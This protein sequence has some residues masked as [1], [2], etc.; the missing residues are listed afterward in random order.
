MI[1]EKNYIHV[2]NN[3]QVG[4]EI[5]TQIPIINMTRHRLHYY[6]N[7]YDQQPRPEIKSSCS[8]HSGYERLE[9]IEETEHGHGPSQ[10]RKNDNIININVMQENTS[11]TTVPSNNSILMSIESTQSPINALKIWNSGEKTDPNRLPFVFKFNQLT[12]ELG[13]NE[14]RHLTLSFCPLKNVLYTVNANC[15]LMCNNFPEI[16]NILPIVIKGNGCKTWFDVRMKS[17]DLSLTSTSNNKR[18]PLI[19]LNNLITRKTL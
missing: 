12:G 4:Y 10:F 17:H 1:G 18:S 6:I 14:K 11:S 13:P 2:P 8:S 7:T 19:N 5:N 3:V 9:K 16:V 15:V